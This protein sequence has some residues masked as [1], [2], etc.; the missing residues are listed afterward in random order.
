MVVGRR[1]GH[2]FHVDETIARVSL[3]EL[4]ELPADDVETARSMWKQFVQINMDKEAILHAFTERI[5]RAWEAEK[6]VL[7]N[8]LD[9]SSVE[10]CHKTWL[11]RSFLS[12]LREHVSSSS[13]GVDVGDGVGGAVACALPPTAYR[14]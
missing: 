13:G 1:Y 6:K 12:L 8:F 7:T 3:I 11:S 5:A 10:Q 14:I 4:A 2:C 9:T